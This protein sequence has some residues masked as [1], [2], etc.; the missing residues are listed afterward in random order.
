MT[1]PRSSGIDLRLG[2]G[3]DETP[4]AARV[5]RLLAQYLV[6]QVPR[7]EQHLVGHLLQ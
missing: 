4:A 7:E 2:D 1:V 6:G 3:D 5:L